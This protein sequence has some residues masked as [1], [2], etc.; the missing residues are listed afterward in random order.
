M[1]SL[2]S[3]NTI[4]WTHAVAFSL[5]SL[6]LIGFLVRRNAIVVLMCV[7]MMLNSVNLILVEMATRMNA[8]EGLILV[9]FT[10]TVAAAEAAVGLG[11]ILNLY[12]LKGTVDL[13]SFH[14]L[15]G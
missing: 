3:S 10:I 14:V 15:K 6:G 5:F 13:D 9:I 7:E 4:F 1:I 8:T 2:A 12:R 11:M